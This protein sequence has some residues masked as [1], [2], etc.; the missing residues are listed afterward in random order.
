M[1]HAGGELWILKMIPVDVADIYEIRAK[2]VAVRG[3]T[4]I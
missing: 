4:P 2:Q 1:I 3:F